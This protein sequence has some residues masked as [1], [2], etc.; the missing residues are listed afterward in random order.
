MPW[1]RTSKLPHPARPHAVAASLAS[2][3]QYYG[4]AAP[5]EFTLPSASAQR[6]ALLVGCAPVVTTESIADRASERARGHIA[7]RR[8]C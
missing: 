2:S 7:A 1:L 5:S 3:L 8:S 6:R 4:L